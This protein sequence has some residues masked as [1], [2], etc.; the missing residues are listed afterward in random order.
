TDTATNRAVWSKHS[1]YES[2]GPIY[3]VTQNSD[4]SLFFGSDGK[5]YYMQPDTSGNYSDPTEI[6]FPK[7]INE[8]VQ[9]KYLTGKICFLQSSGIYIFDEDKQHII[10][11]SQS[12]PKF[13]QYLTNY[14]DIWTK[15]NQWQPADTS[16]RYKNS[17]YLNLFNKIRTIYSDQT[18]NIWLI[19]QSQELYKI[20]QDTTLTDSVNFQ[21]Y[22]TSV[23]DKKDSLYIPEHPRFSFDRNAV[24]IKLSAPCYLSNQGTQ[25]R[26]KIQG[27]DNYEDWSPWSENPIIELSFIPSGNYKLVVNAKN[28]LGDISDEKTMK[29]SVEIPFTE[30]EMFYFIVSL[31]G[32]ALF[33]LIFFAGRYRL[34]LKNKKLE[35]IITE[36]TK[37]I[38]EKNTE[39]QTQKEEIETQRDTLA[40]QKDEIESQRDSLSEKNVEIEKQNKHI[41]DSISYAK[42]IQQAILPTQL[43]IKN[44]LPDNFIYYRP[45]DI[46][47]GDFYWFAERKDS[48][49][50][51][52]ADCTGH[53]VP[54]AFMSMLG[55][56]L[57]NNIVNS[58]R[59]KELMPSDILSQLTE[60]IIESL[61][62]TGD[63]DEAKDGMDISLCKIDRKTN[64]AVFA[65]AFNPLYLVWNDEIR[66]IEP[67]RRPVGIYEFQDKVKPFKDEA[68]DVRKGDMLYSFSDGYVD[69]FGGK[70]GRKFNIG[71]FKKLLLKIH[72]LP[73]EEQQKKIHETMHLWMKD[74]PSQ[75]DDML[76]VGVRI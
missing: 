17:E 72:K 8:P 67:N 73:L 62:Q 61:H 28:I 49:Y 22:I 23:T 46:V 37:E 19:N 15:V 12:S 21:V 58:S 7:K 29:L 10:A 60:Q 35:A 38:T 36:R 68:F 69:Q 41:T 55:V 34:K 44:L 39:L 27:L 1:L 11:P 48:V 53:G 65:G 40:G 31:S 25:Y 30:T 56:S 71:N 66:V 9:V 3:S 14:P 5:A 16:R 51:A 32:L 50:F 47:S 2:P 6:K 54:G 64:K 26:Y 4:K 42:N 75:I 57:L 70:R 52:A 18:K 76:I 45:K 43:Q 33:L 63:P 74:E 13:E 20:S 24:R 59:K